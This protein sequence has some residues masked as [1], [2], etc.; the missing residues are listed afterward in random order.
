M[1]QFFDKSGYTVSVVQG[2]H[3]FARQIDRQSAL[4][5]AEKGKRGAQGPIRNRKKVEKISFKTEKPKKNSIKAEN[6]MQN[7]QN[8]YIF[9]SWLL[10]L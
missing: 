4:Q 5:M 10:K 9:T 8:R 6:R 1:C 7:Y 3:H 2:G